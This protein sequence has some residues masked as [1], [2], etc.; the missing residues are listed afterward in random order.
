MQVFVTIVFLLA[1]MFC[2]LPAFA[3]Q[4]SAAPVKGAN[5]TGGAIAESDWTELAAAAPTIISL[6]PAA[7]PI[8]TLVT[9]SGANFTPKENV[10][11]FRGAREFSAGSPVDS[12]TGTSLQ[13]PVTTCPSYAPRCPGYYIDPG[14]YKVMVINANGMSNEATFDLISR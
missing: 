11:R 10:I 6:S 5:S 7:G 1:A 13:F 14:I 8:G 4:I 12:E 9:I 3:D 2:P